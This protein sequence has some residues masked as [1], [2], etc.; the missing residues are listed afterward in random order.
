MR[1]SVRESLRRFFVI[2]EL[3]GCMMADGIAGQENG[4]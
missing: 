1:D 3:C 4:F 2:R